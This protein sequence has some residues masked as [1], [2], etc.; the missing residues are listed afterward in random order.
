MTLDDPSA[1]CQD[2][3]WVDGRV[4]GRAWLVYL[5]LYLTGVIG[6]KMA[7][8]VLLRHPFI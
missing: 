8:K 3:I 2:F 1:G 7:K 5:I 6:V 4:V